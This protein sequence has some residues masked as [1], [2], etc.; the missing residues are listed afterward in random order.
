MSDDYTRKTLFEQEGV[1]VADKARGETLASFLR[2]FRAQEGLSDDV[3]ITY[4]G[5]L[6]PMAE[7][8]MILLVGDA[9]FQ[10]ERFIGL[11][12]MY[13]TEIVFGVTTDTLDGL[14]IVERIGLVPTEAVVRDCLLELPKSLELLYPRYSSK[15]VAGKPLFVHAR[16]GTRVAVPKRAMQILN[17]EILAA[18]LV[19]GSALVSDTLSTITNVSGD[20]RQEEC[21]DSW[22][23][24]ENKNRE[25]LFLK[26]TIRFTVSSGTYIRALA[27]HIGD[28]LG[29]VAYAHT[30]KRILFEK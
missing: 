23:V 11:S 28:L 29:T 1:H 14:G 20:F 21:A 9:R 17:K 6:D 22:R 19:S 25:T 27:A 16:A 15:P 2:R 24:F 30:I 26:V 10:K 13:E 12:K 4:A 18:A 7:G 8:A 5:R 3:K